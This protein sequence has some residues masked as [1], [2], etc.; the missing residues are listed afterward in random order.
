MENYKGKKDN[1]IETPVKNAKK[2]RKIVFDDDN[3]SIPFTID[4][5]NFLI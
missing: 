2:I 3:G 4:L 5:K 1:N